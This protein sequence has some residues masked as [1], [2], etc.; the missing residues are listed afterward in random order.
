[1]TLHIEINIDNASFC[2]EPGTEVARILRQYATNVDGDNAEGLIYHFIDSN[3]NGVGKAVV[4][5][6]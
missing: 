3:G 5:E 2:D 6:P 4:V 1:M